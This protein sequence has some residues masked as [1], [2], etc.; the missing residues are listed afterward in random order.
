MYK[1][2]PD[3]IS[4]DGSL[5]GPQPIVPYSSLFVFSE[6]NR[7]VYCLKFHALNMRTV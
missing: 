6:Q 7:C 1:A 2:E 5:F 3:K 4:E